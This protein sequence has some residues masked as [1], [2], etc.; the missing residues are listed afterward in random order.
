MSVALPVVRGRGT[1][2]NPANRF[3]RLHV[4]RSGWLDPD[5]PGPRTELLT[6]RARSILSW[7]DSPD[8]GFDVALNPY[9]GCEH[10]CVYCYARP[11]HEYV[12]MSAGLD[13]ESRIFVKREAPEL[14]RS[15][16]SAR[17]WTPRTIMMSGVTDPY[18]PA[19]R[20]LRLTRRC[21]EVLAEFRNPV[22]IITK[23]YLVTRDVDILA[24]MAQRGGAAVVLSV[25]SLRN[26]IQRTLEPRA[27][28][29]SR[30][31]GAIRVLADAGIPVGV[32]VAPVIPGLTDHEVPAILEAAAE[33][34]ASFAGY[35]LLRLPHGVKNL[36]EQWLSAHAPDRREKVLNRLRSL[37]GGKLYDA[38]YAVRGRGEGPFAEQLR[39]MFEVSRRRVG[40][41][42]RPT[43]SVE[44]F[45]RPGDPD[46][47]QMELFAG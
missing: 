6:D 40:L 30:R 44:H 2:S 43:L 14:L 12:G 21:L 38:R 32:N 13:F 31:L 18:Q 46:D 28:S 3:E 5:D 19:E 15:A 42:Q 8:V 33:A 36:F 29:P 39:S 22:G 11:N 41:E 17:S 35:I 20:R 27:S 26:E 1:A 24:E 25:T 9:R 4:D 23:S 16:L 7:N 45:R 47:T 37:R 34:G 10:G